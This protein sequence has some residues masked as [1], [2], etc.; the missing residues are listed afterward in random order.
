M[1]LSYVGLESWAFPSLSS[2]QLFSIVCGNN[3]TP[4][5]K[6]RPSFKAHCSLVLLNLMCSEKKCLPCG[7]NRADRIFN[8]RCSNLI[9]LYQHSRCAG[10]CPQSQV[11]L[12]YNT[13][14]RSRTVAIWVVDTMISLSRF[15]GGDNVGRVTR[16]RRIGENWHDV[17][18]TGHITLVVDTS[19]FHQACLSLTSVAW[20][21]DK[22]MSLF[23]TAEKLQNKP[24]DED[25][26]IKAYRFSCSSEG[27]QNSCTG[28][29]LQKERNS[30]KS[31]FLCSFH[32]LKMKVILNVAFWWR[33]K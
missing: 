5:L 33:W 31:F 21:H 1:S 19:C 11:T 30:N 22:C 3:L 23:Q 12:W 26:L 6:N 9:L 2:C 14:P 8:C 20:K 16:F 4:A 15:I 27:W 29:N 10:L 18:W 17:V 25:D 7:G 28:Q 24:Q 32:E 13:W